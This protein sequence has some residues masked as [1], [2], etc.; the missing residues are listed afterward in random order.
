VYPMLRAFGRFVTTAGTY[1]QNILALFGLAVLLAAG[2]G[3]L[4]QTLVPLVEQLDQWLFLWVVVQIAR[5]LI[6]IK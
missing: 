6:H 5:W 3:L 4:L 2:L 1:A